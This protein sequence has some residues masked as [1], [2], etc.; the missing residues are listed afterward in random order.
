MTSPTIHAESPWDLKPSSRAILFI[1][2]AGSLRVTKQL[3]DARAYHLLK[4]LANSIREA[5][6][7]SGRVVR[8][9]G[10]GFL[11]AFDSVDDAL[12]HAATAQVEVARRNPTEVPLKIRCGVHY[13]EVIEAEDDVFG[14]AVYL[15]NRVTSHAHGGEIL[16]TGAARDQSEMADREFKE[17]GPTLLPGFEDPVPLYEFCGR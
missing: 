7:N 1:D 13:G 6:P 3:G 4:F 9:L 8:S 17:F 11:L 5:K 14:I 12:T 15:A 10:D 2:V 16:L